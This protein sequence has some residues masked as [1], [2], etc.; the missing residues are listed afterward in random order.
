MPT[1]KY[2]AISQA[3]AETAGTVDAESL[4]AARRKL[5]G[6]G[7]YPVSLSERTEGAGLLPSV[8][9]FGRQDFLPLFT[10]QLATLVGAGV[11]VM[12][13]LESL[14]PQVEDPRSRRLVEEIREGVRTGASLG[15]AMEGH[16]ETF[17]PL[18]AGMV[19]A[20]EESGSLAL[21]LSRLADYIEGQ[22]R[23]KTR[24]RTAL[25]YPV[26]MGIVGIS[27]IAFLMAFVVPKIVAV[28]APL[29]K[30]LPL[31]TRILIA[32]SDAVAFGWWAMLLAVIA[33]V[34]L[35][36]RF[37]ATPRGM[38][39]RDALLLRLPLAGRVI[40]LSALSRFARTFST[41]ASGGIPVDKALGIVAPVVGNVLL[42]EEIDRAGVRVVE[43]ASLSDS[44]K[45]RPF[46]PATL[47]QMISVGE[48]S[49]TLD[50][51][52]GKLA[53]ALDEEIDARLSR[54]LTLLEPLIIL[55]MGVIVT[56][57]VVSVMLPLLEI[58][59]IVR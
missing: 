38:R 22:S 33:L 23:T 51:M 19:K 6:D 4:P 16:P 12:S 40:H 32:V 59:R 39:T 52:L 37:L 8:S 3:G 11:P 21:A 7:V 56:F 17:P 48:E 44:L 30:A 55:A 24:V 58:S 29:G 27:V 14:G 36:R 15:R 20:G 53:D 47:I 45:G 54:M 43:G 1:Y 35:A 18:Y 34:L 57:I 13:A 25:A 42:S 26:L 50:T 31:P 2:T 5:R 9:L 28:F 49:G 46:F 10:R 41:L